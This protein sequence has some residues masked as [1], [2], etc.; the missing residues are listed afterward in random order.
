MAKPVIATDVPG[1]RS[2]VDDGRTGL[3]C[4]PRSSLSLAKAMTAFLSMS[5]QDRLSMGSRGREKAEQEFSQENVVDAYLDALR[6]TP[7]LTPAAGLPG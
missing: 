7:I 2:V 1:C 4:E 5:P 3:L 6:I